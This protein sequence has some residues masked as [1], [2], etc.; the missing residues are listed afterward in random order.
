MGNKKRIKRGDKEF[1]FVFLE[2]IIGRVK[3]IYDRKPQTLF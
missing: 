1:F 3:G 2:K